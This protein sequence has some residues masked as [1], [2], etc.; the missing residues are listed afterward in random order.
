MV[1]N[2][3]LPESTLLMLVAAFVGRDRVLD[4]YREAVEAR[5]R[6]FPTGMRCSVNASP[7]EIVATDGAA[8]RGRLTTGHSTVETPVFMPCG[9]YG[10][11]KGM[12]PARLE[13]VGTQ[14]LL[15]N[16]FHL[17]LRPGAEAI[18]ALGGLHRFMSWSG[19]ILTDS[20]GFQVFS[21]RDL[22]KV[23]EDGVEFRSPINGDKVFLS[24]ERSMDVQHLL[25]SDIVMSFDECTPFPS[26]RD[27]ARASMELSMRW[28]RRGREHHG[29]RDGLLFGIV[30]GG[31]FED[32]RTG[33][34]RATR[35]NLLPGLRDRWSLGR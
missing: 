19:S 26:T 20:G 34:P 13:D 4:A 3:H 7:L 30:Q 12:T 27:E 25:G 9:T 23:T 35:R 15:G 28:A 2:F 33:E 29:D 1:T 14:I 32:L 31:M 21:L 18:A 17:M 22:R 6:F 10:A 11:V 5:Y 8:R 24:P 16:T